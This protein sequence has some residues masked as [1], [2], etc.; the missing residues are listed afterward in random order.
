MLD[1]KFTLRL[2]VLGFRTHRAMIDLALRVLGEQAGLV[3]G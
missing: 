3:S 1:G 2:A